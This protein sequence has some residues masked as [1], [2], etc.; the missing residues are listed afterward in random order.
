MPGGNKPSRVKSGI[1]N[2]T[3]SLYVREN[4]SHCDD[5]RAKP[6]TQT[7][8]TEKLWKHFY[9]WPMVLFVVPLLIGG[10]MEVIGWSP[11]EFLFAK[12]CFAVSG[13]I[14]LAKVVHWL[15]GTNSSQGERMIVRF[16]IFGAI[17]VGLVESLHWVR[18]RQQSAQ[19]S[20]ATTPTAT[21]IPEL[22]MS[23]EDS[24]NVKWL[25]T[26]HSS[27]VAQPVKYWFG[28]FDLDQPLLGGD[29]AQP[30]QIPAATRANI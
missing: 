6:K 22:S 14:L 8:Q 28:L 15:V 30:L 18:N 9:G 21:A 29:L 11:P 2:T 26:N 27:V 25:I 13:L 23:F 5:I 24:A 4:N 1:I 12:L 10:G 16:L 20:I 17:G 3:L 7:G 19:S